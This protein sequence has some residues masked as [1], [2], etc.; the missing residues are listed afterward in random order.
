M[1]IRDIPVLLWQGESEICGF[2]LQ[3]ITYPIR[4]PFVSLALFRKIFRKII[5]NLINKNNR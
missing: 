3:L 2:Y 4:H 1:R 5:N